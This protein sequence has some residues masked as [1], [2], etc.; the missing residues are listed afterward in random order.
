MKPACDDIHVGLGEACERSGSGAGCCYVAC[1]RTGRE[2]GTGNRAAR[3]P[4]VFPEF[5]RLDACIS[6]AQVARVFSS[7]PVQGTK[8]KFMI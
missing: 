4:T 1:P 3:R 2:N 8:D 7:G 5:S 6:R